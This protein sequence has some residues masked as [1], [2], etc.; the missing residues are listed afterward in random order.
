[1][2]PFAESPQYNEDSFVNNAALFLNKTND[3]EVMTNESIAATDVSITSKVSSFY[4]KL[5]DFNLCCTFDQAEIS[6]PNVNHNKIQ[7]EENETHPMTS[8]SVVDNDYFV[9]ETDDTN[10]VGNAKDGNGDDHNEHVE[11]EGFVL[12]ND[13]CRQ[14]NDNNHNNIDEEKVMS[15]N[16][17]TEEERATNDAEQTHRLVK[18]TRMIFLMNKVEGA[19]CHNKAVT[20]RYESSSAAKSASIVEANDDDEMTVPF[21]NRSCEEEEKKPI[22]STM[23]HA[24]KTADQSKSLKKKIRVEPMTRKKPNLFV[25]GKKFVLVKKNNDNNIRTKKLSTKKKLWSAKYTKKVSPMKKTEVVAISE[26]EGMLLNDKMKPSMMMK[27]IKKP[28]SL[29]KFR[30]NRTK[31]DASSTDSKKKV[32]MVKRIKKSM[33]L[34]KIKSKQT[35]I[36]DLSSSNEKKKKL[37]MVK[38]ITKSMS[39][40][41]VNSTQTMNRSNLSSSNLKKKKSSVVK[42]IKRSLSLKKMKSIRKNK[43]KAFLLTN[44]KK[45]SSMM[46]KSG[47]KSFSL[48]KKKNKSFEKQMNLMG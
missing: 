22:I 33:S 19:D 44:K 37:S 1:M 45:K 31:S 18:E 36:S 40:K 17:N 41:K 28:M 9:A 34:T 30:S 47:K 2:P 11:E 8:S 25:R 43:S 27:C 48:K 29:P 39:L 7:E 46:M 32:S 15:N 23:Y 6:L 20:E 42:S 3:N 38:R 5:F 13:T 14:N 21:K 26:R 24:Q 16:N 35:T 12:T 10:N 4:E